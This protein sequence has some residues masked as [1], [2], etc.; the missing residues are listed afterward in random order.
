MAELGDDE[1]NRISHRAEAVRAMRP[2]LQALIESRRAAVARA[3]SR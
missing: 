1:K 2:A 3:V